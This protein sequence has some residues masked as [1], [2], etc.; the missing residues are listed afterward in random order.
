M[1]LFDGDSIWHCVISELLAGVLPVSQ[2]TRVNRA[3]LDLCQIGFRALSAS[4][5]AL[6][7]VRNSNLIRM[8]VFLWTP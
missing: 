1:G 4:A 3:F 6:E 8:G 2:P 7:N 5:Y